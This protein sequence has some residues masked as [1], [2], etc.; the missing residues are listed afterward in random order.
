MLAETLFPGGGAALV[1]AWRIRQFEDTWLRTVAG[2][3]SDF[4]RVT[5]DALIFAAK[6]MKLDLPG[7]KRERLLGAFP[8]ARPVAGRRSGAKDA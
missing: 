2:R 6:A 7:D 4:M 5:D 3:Y 1:S 8:Q